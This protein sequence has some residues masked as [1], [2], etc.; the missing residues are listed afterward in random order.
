MNPSVH[1]HPESGMTWGSTTGMIFI[2][3]DL[4]PR[5]LR[6]VLLHEMCHIGPQMMDAHGPRWLRKIARLVRRGETSLRK[7]LELYATPILRQG[8]SLLGS[9]PLFRQWVEGTGIFKK[10]AK[11]KK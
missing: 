8:M 6:R 1:V 10:K 11:A 5:Q 2:R 3:E 7:D 9:P 4:G